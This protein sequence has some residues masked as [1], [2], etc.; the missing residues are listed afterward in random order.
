MALIVAAQYVTRGAGQLVTGSCVNLILAVAAAICSLGWA[1]AVAI[2]SPLCAFLLGIGPA[3]ILLVPAIALG[4]GLYVVILSLT[5][6]KFG[7]AKG[8]AVLGVGAAS[9][10]KCGT[11]WGVIVGLLLP[12]MA[13]P[14]A[15][16]AALAATFSWPQ[17]VTALVGG[18][19]SLLVIPTLQKAI[20]K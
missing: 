20:R 2:L 9:V 6:R 17:L 11:L 19:V 18:T 14:D 7:T 8:G 12:M 16:A 3:L 10:V 4:N 15:K 13:L 1:L 5:A